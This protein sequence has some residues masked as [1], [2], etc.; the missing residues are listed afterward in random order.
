[1][2][3]LPI[4]VYPSRLVDKLLC[5]VSCVG[6][7]LAS[8]PAACVNLPCY[9]QALYVSIRSV[10]EQHLTDFLYSSFQAEYHDKIR[11]NIHGYLPLYS[12]T[13]LPFMCATKER[14]MRK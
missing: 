4:S 5:A 3:H 13:P 1:M 9:L 8:S 6:T 12:V 14:P 2:H 10:D 11:A 7:P